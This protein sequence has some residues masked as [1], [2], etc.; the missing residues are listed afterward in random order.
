MM[1]AA[2]FADWDN[3]A[4][5]GWVDRPPVRCILGEGEVGPSVV[6]MDWDNR[7]ELGW[8]TLAQDD[9]VVEAVAPDQADKAFGER[10]LPGAVRRRE[11]FVDAHALHAVPKVL[12]VDLVTVS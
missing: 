7:A 5:L 3:R 10:I 9:H 11:D 8:V 12:A 4:E 6:V 2:D 1:Q